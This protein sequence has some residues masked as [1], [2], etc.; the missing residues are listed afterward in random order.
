MR[1]IILALPLALA[2]TSAHAAPALWRG[3]VQVTAIAEATTGACHG[4]WFP[5]LYFTG[6]YQPGGLAGNG[7]TDQF[8]FF[9][10]ASSWQFTVTGGTKAAPIANLRFITRFGGSGARDGAQLSGAATSPAIITTTTGNVSVKF[11][12][13]DIFNNVGCKASFYGVLQKAL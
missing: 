5:G 13:P 12:V 7:A 10:E 6:I 2:F 3:E 8:S 1:P 11:T 9:R 4:G